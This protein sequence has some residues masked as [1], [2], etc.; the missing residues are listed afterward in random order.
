MRTDAKTDAN[1]TAIMW[2]F[3][4][5]GCAVQSVATVGKGCPD[6]I[7]AFGGTTTLVEVKDGNK[8]PSAQKLTA[9]QVKWHSKWPAKVWIVRNEMDV[10]EVVMWLRQRQEVA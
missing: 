6:L 7:V 5:A 1:Q 9:D 4:K 3:R 2:C 10:A 8:A